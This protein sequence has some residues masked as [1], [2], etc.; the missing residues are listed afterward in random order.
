MPSRYLGI[1]LAAG[2]G[3]R[4]GQPKI[5]AHGGAWL[6][7][8]TATLQQG[9]CARVYIATGAARPPLPPGTT[10]IHVPGWNTGLG[11]TVH[12]AITALDALTCNND[13]RDG[14]VLHTIDTPDVGADVLARLIDHHPGSWGITRA[15][16]QGRPGHPVIIGRDHWQPLLASLAAD[17][18]GDAGARHYLRGQ[19]V[20]GIECGDLATGADI[21]HPDS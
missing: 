2:A 1:I 3:N 20:I 14:L 21:D 10:E 7:T 13:D 9:G 4:Y 17:A 8:A 15:L 11:T 19:Q 12:A 18:S 16:Y 5:L 6:R